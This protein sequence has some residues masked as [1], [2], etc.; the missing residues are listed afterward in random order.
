M[1]APPAPDVN[2]VTEELIDSQARTQFLELRAYD[3]GG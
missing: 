2:S 1:T 3:V